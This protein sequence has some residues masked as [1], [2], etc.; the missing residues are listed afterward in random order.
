MI[1]WMF[2]KKDLKILQIG[3]LWPSKVLAKSLLTF[4]GGMTLGS[5]NTGNSHDMDIFVRF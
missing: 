4:S 2:A 3:Y 5:L 1:L